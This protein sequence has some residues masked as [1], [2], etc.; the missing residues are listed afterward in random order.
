MSATKV[1]SASKEHRLLR[2]PSVIEKTGLSRSTIYRR[3]AQG[4]FPSR[5]KVGIRT[6]AWLCADVDRWIGDRIRDTARGA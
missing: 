2:L 4:T 5:I 3:E 6:T 1:T